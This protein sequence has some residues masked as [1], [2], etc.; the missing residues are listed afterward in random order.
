MEAGLTAD[1]TELTPIGRVLRMTRPALGGNINATIVSHFP[2][3]ATVRPGVFPD[4]VPEEGRKGTAISRP[5]RITV[6]MERVPVPSVPDDDIADARILVSVGNGVRDRASVDVAREV[7]ARLGA[8]LSCSRAVADKGWLPHSAQ[9][10]Q[11]G[12][13]VSPDLYIAFGIS[14]SVQHLAGLRAK[15]VIAVNRDRDAPIMGIA[16]TAVIGDADA[17]LRKLRDSLKQ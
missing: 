15:R 10:G 6:S 3:M 9:V 16:D 4:P 1:C 8:K 13:T 2:Q 17:I 7:A 5:Y 11:S 12:R 14:G